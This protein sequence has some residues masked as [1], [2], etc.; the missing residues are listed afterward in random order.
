MEPVLVIFTVSERVFLSPLSKHSIS[1]SL[2]MSEMFDL[3][4]DQGKL[5]FWSEIIQL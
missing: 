5:H 1:H 3:F 2:K 4:L